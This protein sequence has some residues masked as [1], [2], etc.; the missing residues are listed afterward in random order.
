M[1]K[2]TG[3]FRHW[4]IAILVCPTSL[5]GIAVASAQSP[6]ELIHQ[7]EESRK[8]IKP[9]S[10]IYLESVRIDGQTKP[11]SNN[12]ILPSE[13]NVVHGSWGNVN[14]DLYYE[15]AIDPEISYVRCI[16]SEADSKPSMFSHEYLSTPKLFSEA[17]D[18][19]TRGSFS[20]QRGRENTN[21]AG[22]GYE[23][24]QGESL[25]RFLTGSTDLRLDSA[26]NLSA[27]V[28]G[29]PIQI[30]IHRSGSQICMDG[31]SRPGSSVRIISWKNYLGFDYPEKVSI[32]TTLNFGHMR[33]IAYT[34]KTFTP[35]PDTKGQKL[36]WKEG[37][38]IMDSD[39]SDV[40]SV[41]N[42][43]LVLNLLFDKKKTEKEASD[44]AVIMGSV[45]V[46][47]M[48]GTGLVLRRISKKNVH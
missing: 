9:F 41:V 7:I 42:G 10:A 15:Y 36:N 44:R 14:T 13:S 5:L 34:F 40:Y 12:G 6:Q 8:A 46:L 39:S 32:S 20:L 43:Q 1:Q 18:E 31:Y 37:A 26:G 16:G 17:I 29:V 21:P 38:L 33:H 24:W 27:V 47:A 28:R 11:D 35:N 3:H 19:G 45:V 30:G 25:S 48:G 4:T 23:L 2:F 22:M